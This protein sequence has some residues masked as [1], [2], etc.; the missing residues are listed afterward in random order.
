[1]QFEH[2]G[3]IGS[4]I[5][6]KNKNKNNNNNNNN[7]NSINNW[8]LKS[9]RYNFKIFVFIKLK[10]FPILFPYYIFYSNKWFRLN[11]L[12]GGRRYNQK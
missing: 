11:K 12:I 6:K 8:S 3:S 5:I 7:N 4:H 1:M 10:F 9:I 2:M